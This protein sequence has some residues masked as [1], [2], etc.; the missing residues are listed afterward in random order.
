M[1]WGIVALIVFS[2][3]VAA[4]VAW[5]LWRRPGAGPVEPWHTEVGGREA[6]GAGSRRPGRG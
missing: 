2:L 6:G 4:I 5:A 3:A 1:G